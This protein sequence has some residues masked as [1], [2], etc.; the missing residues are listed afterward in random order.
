LVLLLLILGSITLHELGHTLVAQRY[1]ISVQDIILTP[2]GGVAV[3]SQ[4][5]PIPGRRSASPSPDRWSASPSPC[6]P[7]CSSDSADPCHCPSLR[8]SLA[9]RFAST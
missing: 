9:F 2:I 8:T 3:C 4:P 1:G 6:S 5:P 7:H